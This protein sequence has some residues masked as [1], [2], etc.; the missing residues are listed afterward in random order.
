MTFCSVGCANDKCP[1][2][3]TD[4]IREEA[5]MLGLPVSLEF[6]RV[7]SCGYK[8]PPDKKGIRKGKA[9]R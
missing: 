7:K 1:R 9:K 8:R 6:M 4:D 5:E 3:L 2:L